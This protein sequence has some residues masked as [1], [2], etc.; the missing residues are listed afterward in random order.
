MWP[1]D[2]RQRESDLERELRSHLNAEAEDYPADCLTPDEARY[3]ARRRL[4]N[5]ALIQED[6]RAMWGWTPLDTLWQD[7]RYA[8]RIL[9]RNP[10]FSAAAALALALGIGA[11]TA[12][13]SVFESALLR[14]LPFAQP[15]RVVRLWESYGVKGLTTVVS[16]PN[17]KD[18]RDWNHTFSGM[19]AYTRGSA[20]LTGRGEPRHLSGMFAS[21]PLLQ[22]LGV[23]PA[24]GRAFRPEEDQPFAN[25]GA[26][27]VMISEALW[28]DVLGGRAGPLGEKLVLSGEPYTVVG[29]LPRELDERA[30]FGK[31]DF[32]TTFGPVAAPRPDL[33]RPT[34]EIRTISNY[35]AIGRLKPGV[36]LAQAQADMDR[37]AALLHT[38]YPVDDPQEGVAIVPWRLSITGD[39][40]PVLT[41]LL[42]CAGFVLLVACADIAGLV[43]ARAAARQ[44]EMA[45]RSA[46]GAGRW[47]I[48]RQLLVESL[49]MAAVGC[50][51]GVWLASFLGTL[52]DNSLKIRSAPR[53]DLTVFGFAALLAVLAATICSLAPVVH[54][55]RSNLIARL[56]ESSLNASVGAGQRRSYGLLVVVQMALAMVL[57]SASGLLSMS[58]FQLQSVALGFTPTRALT[59]PVSLDGARYHQSQRA[60][61]FEELTRRLRAIPG[62]AAVGAG[63]QLPLEGSTSRTV[64]DAAAGRPVK[65]SGIVFASITPQ[66]FQALGISVRRGREF[67]D[68]DTATAP[69]VVILN[70]AAVRYY[71]PKGDPVGQTV[72]PEMW[73]GSGSK[74][75]PRTVVGVVPDIRLEGLTS[76]TPP[77]IYW[78]ITQIP[79]DSRLFVSV[80][81]GGNPLAVVGAVRQQL[82]AVDADLP[83]YDLFLLDHYVGEQLALPRSTT[84]L[85]GGMALLALILTAVGL[86]GVTA[87]AV[88]RRT[89]EIGI[90]VALGA[91]R[92]EILR[93][94]LR[95]G[96]AAAI[97]GVAIGWPGAVAAAR[98]LRSLLFGVG[99]QETVILASG[100]LILILVAAV[101]SYL[102]ARRATRVEPITAL[103]WE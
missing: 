100:A 26:N 37:V 55:F 57:L 15:D 41:L 63:G 60:P 7:L 52:L 61:F 46:I 33:P 80:M 4:G 59:F 103:R 2:R 11:N 16:Y 97:L 101:A 95:S 12:V 1:F 3:A 19:A 85:V 58:L 47:R 35:S 50:A 83:L 18:W 21:A 73:N 20:T 66:Y 32:L 23:Q 98:L 29:V 99:K 56:R 8:G 79:C 49:V 81:A 90:R 13:F 36:T 62:V 28:H 84:V 24:L 9:R 87:Y 34:T 91:S 54:Y 71:L 67:T 93:G 40:R 5:I 64:L 88:A 102:P 96:I 69:P 43:L 77:A 14:P 76:S 75:R 44:R 94:F 68:A 53:L 92:S 39:V 38:T 27:S 78:P 82:H 65:R 72:T 17:F 30:G 74:T 89:R 70:E 31:L 45:V 6:T 22:I 86:Y 42:A 10:G 51:A 25:A 48:I